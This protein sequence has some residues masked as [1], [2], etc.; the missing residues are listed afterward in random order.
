MSNAECLEGLTEGNL[1]LI[2]FT[3]IGETH[4]ID[5]GR[6]RRCGFHEAENPEKQRDE[7]CQNDQP[8]ERFF[9]SNNQSDR[10]FSADSRL[11]NLSVHLCFSVD[12]LRF[13]QRP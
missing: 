5:T 7:C 3:S 2:R 6:S 13:I 1:G 12:P 4:L 9:E 8:I 10:M 11:R